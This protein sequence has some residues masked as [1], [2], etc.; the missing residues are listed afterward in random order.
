MVKMTVVRIRLQSVLGGRL[1]Y[2]GYVAV[3]S[4]ADF[5]A[6]SVKHSWSV[7]MKEVWFSRPGIASVFTPRAGT[8]HEWRTS[9]AV[10][11][12]RM[13]DSM[14]ITMRW[15]TSSRRKWPRGGLLLGLC[16]SQMRGPWS[17]CIHRFSIIGVRW[18]LG[19]DQVRRFRLLCRGFGGRGG[20]AGLG[21]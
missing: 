15:S 8:A 2:N 5:W 12:T 11:I 16:R 1:Y 19:W 14:G 13:G 6:L 9:S 21:Q 4:S 17:L 18:L 7:V 3:V 20:Q 10:M